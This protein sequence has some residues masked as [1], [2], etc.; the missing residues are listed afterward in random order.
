MNITWL[1]PEPPLPPYTGGRERT[2]RLLEYVAARHRVHLLTY[3]TKADAAEL[4]KLR[5]ALA[6][7]TALPYP[8]RGQPYGAALA[9]ALRQR[10]A[11]GQACEA[12]HVQSLTL[13]PGASSAARRAAA[14]PQLVLDLSDVP[15]LLRE[16]VQRLRNTQTAWNWLVLMALRLREAHALRQ[17]GSII[18]AS[19]HDAARLQEAVGGRTINVVTVPNGVDCEYWASTPA[20]LEAAAPTLLFAGAL[21]YPPNIDAAR[22]LVQDVLP[23]VRAAVPE[24]RAIVA[25]RAAG[26]ETLAL[27]AAHPDLTLRVDVPDMRPLLAQA[28]VVVVPL[29]AGSGTRLKILQALAAG[30]PMVSTP[31]GAE[32]LDLEAGRHLL[33]APLVDE[34]SA[35][36]VGL[37]RDPA[38]RAALAAAGPGAVAP[39]AW[40][41]QLPRLEAVYPQG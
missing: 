33:I 15:S 4:D 41:R 9:G 10:L 2:R 26:Q 18:A 24:A 34:F 21:N 16:R 6:G 29:R 31:L 23:R 30:R 36:V 5:P 11:M 3:A 19:A 17:A 8:G 14:R 12:V 28:A 27:A 22:I 40:E 20:G 13:W 37:L 39:Y 35:A 32:G 38:A 25:G 1:T 7:L